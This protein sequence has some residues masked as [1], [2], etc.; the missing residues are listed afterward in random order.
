MDGNRFSASGIELDLPAEGAHP[1]VRG[2]VAFEVEP[3]PVTLAS[4][5]IMGGTATCRGWSATTASL[6]RPRTSG[7]SPSAKTRSSSTVA[8]ATPEGLGHLVSKLLGW[9]QSNR[10]V[11]DNGAERPGVS[12]TLSVTHPLARVQLTGHIAGLLLDDGRLM[13]FATYTGSRL[14]AVET[15]PGGAAIAVR[16]HEHELLAVVTGTRTGELKAPVLGR[17]SVAP[18][19]RSTDTYAWSC[20]PAGRRCCSREQVRAQAPRS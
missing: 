1:P 20:A 15:Y 16:D 3:W 2:A 9:A 12:L 10:F 18:T 14:A 19:K 17:C 8:A 11:D 7:S 5:G 4:P 13:R 6:A